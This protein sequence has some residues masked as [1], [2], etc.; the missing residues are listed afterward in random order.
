MMLDYPT[1]ADRQKFNYRKSQGLIP[2]NASIGGG[3]GIHGTWP[4]DEMAVDYMQQW[5]N[6]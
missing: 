6:G 4:H 5:T 1:V 2:R 3:I